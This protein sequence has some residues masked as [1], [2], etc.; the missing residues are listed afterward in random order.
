MKQKVTI[1][2]A[3]LTL[4][5][6]LAFAQHDPKALKEWQ[7]QKYSMFIHYG[8]YSVLGGVWEGKPVAKGLSEQIQAHAGIYSDTYADV[9]KR[10]NPKSWN[11]D[12]IVSL[13]K[14][15]GMRSIVITSKHHDGFCMFK[16]N[17]TDF[18]VVDATPFKRD[19]VK[20]LSE[21][22]KR[23]G[24]RFGLYFSLIDWHY[25]QA[26]PI[27]S[28]NSDYITPE[29]VQY[30]KKQITELLS[31]YGPISE[32]WF[33]MG[34]QN[35]DESRELRDLVH[36][37]QPD[38]MIGSRIGNDM[39]DFNVMGDNQEPDY[40]IGVPWQSPASFFDETWSYRSWQERGS[41]E[42]KIREKLTSLIKV[43]SRGGNFLL[44][45]G[46]KG[47]G[48]VVDFEK[49]VLLSIGKWL[50]KNK[51]AI[52]GTDPDP[53]HISF[54]WGSLTSRPNK[55]Y[56]HLLSAPENGVIT[57]PGLTGKIKDVYVLGENIKGKFSQNA[58]GVTINV[59]QGLAIEKEFKVIVIE[60]A[61]GYSVPPANIIAFNKAPLILNSHNAFKHYSSSG[62]DYNNRF[63]STVKESWTI[64]P[65]KGG[66]P[67]PV[68][69]Y[70]DEE[71]GKAIDLEINGKTTVVTLNGTAAEKLKNDPAAIKWG[72]IYQSG[73]YYSGV[74]GVHGNLTN[75]DVSRP[76]PNS[77][78]QVWSKTDDRKNNVTYEIEADKNSAT[79]F[80]Q[81]ITS[82]KD[83]SY[84]VG[85]TS[86]DGVT[87]TLNGKVLAEHN[88]PFK[89]KQLKD[90]ILLPLKKGKNQ[91]IVKYYNG[92]KKINVMSID[93]NLNQTVYHQELKPIAV[94]KGK[95]YPISWQLHNPL[96][97]HTTIG[98]FNTRIEIR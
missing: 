63:Q 21:A 40:A 37:L 65:S 79:Y 88:N 56:L 20:E 15:A 66:N 45:I 26:S 14:K 19:V 27:S 90:V 67:T 86:G 95:Y 35:A 22:C 55:I 57:L 6:T 58:S 80:L 50:D 9:A 82:E 83:Q 4:C 43:A 3:L 47:D 34:S 54:K 13:A 92:F 51:E 16:T 77:D 41:E 94:E 74:G 64:S 97:P 28:S 18:N 72:D 91:L 7:D 2:F 5:K 68:I 76:W 87:V 32:L 31:N 70:T 84:L 53:F 23:G 17:T 89:E 69:Y 33:D 39:G 52:Y 59:P 48:S 96:S 62:V 98:L 44:N 1:L 24:L 36:K 49:D 30:N 10:F 60:F 8:I 29:H 73:S 61:N 71:K 42:A 11:A 25:P 81:E 75:V 38:C 46:P 85:I 93:N 78:S 12:S